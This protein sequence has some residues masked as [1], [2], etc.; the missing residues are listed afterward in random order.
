MASPLTLLPQP[1]KQGSHTNPLTFAPPSFLKSELGT[2]ECM[3]LPWDGV[4]HRG[5]NSHGVSRLTFFASL[6]QHTQTCR[7]AVLHKQHPLPLASMFSLRHT[8]SMTSLVHPL[9]RSPLLALPQP[10]PITPSR[11]PAHLHGFSP[12]QRPKALEPRRNAAHLTSPSTTSLHL[13]VNAI[14][15]PR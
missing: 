9:R 1:T 12:S 5:P 2:E 14:H 4:V 15:S 7:R 3:V 8:A 6:L 10:T 13:H 11:P